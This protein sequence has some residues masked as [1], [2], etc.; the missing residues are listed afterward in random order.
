MSDTTKD[1]IEIAVV[2]VVAIAVTK[3]LHRAI[4]IRRSK[5]TAA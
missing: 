4:K 3:T 1:A 5:K 2:A